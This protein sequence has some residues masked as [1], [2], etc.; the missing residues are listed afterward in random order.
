[1][2]CFPA[3]WLLFSGRML[4]EFPQHARSDDSLPL[5]FRRMKSTYSVES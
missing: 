1:M 2:R 4:A 5:D 3:P